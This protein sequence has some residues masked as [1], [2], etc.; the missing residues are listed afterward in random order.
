MNLL[1]RTIMLPKKTCL[2]GIQ[3]I[4]NKDEKMKIKEQTDSMIKFERGSYWGSGNACTKYPWLKGKLYFDGDGETTVTINYNRDFFIIYDS[5]FLT[6]FF[7]FI[8]ILLITIGNRFSLLA[9]F[10]Y[11]TGIFG[12]I[13]SLVLMHQNENK[14]AV[15]IFNFLNE[16]KNGENGERGYFRPERSPLVDLM[17]LCIIVGVI[18]AITLTLLFLG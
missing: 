8:T 13:F 16:F 15:K 14:F 9:I 5:I 7:F 3:G 1:S 10:F 6:Y 4:F 12:L 17:F 2:E 11:I 18:I